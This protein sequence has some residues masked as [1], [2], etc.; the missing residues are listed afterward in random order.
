MGYRV[1][2]SRIGK[3]PA[4]NTQAAAREADLHDA[5]LAFCHAKGWPVVHSRMD[6]PATCG[7]GTPDFVVALPA[8]R[9]VWVEAK[10]ATGKLRPEQAAWLAALRAVGH[11][12]EVVRSI[13]EFLNL[14]SQS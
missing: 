12:A 5:I 13:P 8:G 9:V 10:A 4:A 11:R 6:V 7:V 3:S 2:G 1:D 14:V